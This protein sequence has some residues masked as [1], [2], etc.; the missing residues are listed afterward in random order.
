MTAR[1][2]HKKTRKEKSRRKMK[3]SLPQCSTSS[4][5]RRV[6]IETGFN[7]LTTDWRICPASPFSLKTITKKLWMTL[8]NRGLVRKSKI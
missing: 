1:V 8:N 7:T 6:Q 3:A 5:K 2:S 4:S